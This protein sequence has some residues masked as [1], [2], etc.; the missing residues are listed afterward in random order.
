MGPDDLMNEETGP[1]PSGSLSDRK[2]SLSSNHPDVLGVNQL[3]E[4]VKS[5]TLLFLESS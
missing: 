2:T 5:D 3:L 4:S 1:E